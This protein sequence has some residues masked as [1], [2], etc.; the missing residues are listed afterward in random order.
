M[1]LRCCC[2][3]KQF[4]N[5]VYLP[6]G[7][8]IDN[9]CVHRQ[10]PCGKCPI[11][12][13]CF[14]GKA[15]KAFPENL[16]LQRLAAIARCRKFTALL[17]SNPSC[18]FDD[19]GIDA[20]ASVFCAVCKFRFC[21]RCKALHDKIPETRKHEMY[22][23]ENEEKEKAIIEKGN[24]CKFHNGKKIKSWCFECKLL[25]CVDCC[26]CNHDLVDIS[27][28]AKDAK[29]KVMQIYKNLGQTIT[30]IRKQQEII[31][32][33]ENDLKFENDDHPSAALRF[34]VIK[35]SVDDVYLQCF[36]LHDEIKKMLAFGGDTELLNALKFLVIQH[37]N[38]HKTSRSTEPRPESSVSSDRSSSSNHDSSA[39]DERQSLASNQLID[40]SVTLDYQNEMF[41][42]GSQK[43]KKRDAAVIP[44]N[45]ENIYMNEVS[46]F[47]G[48]KNDIRH[49][50]RSK[51][52]FT[53]YY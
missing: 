2:C 32:G 44:E 46:L 48:I 53:L 42:G 4:I 30:T 45:N 11:C 18:N 1:D 17:S 34:N 7:H 13:E 10:K 52:T 20:A 15:E 25:A 16:F 37:E 27:K 9:R 22:F 6:C 38:I 35:G 51:A 40:T 28:A 12:K 14:N 19:H 49:D 5:P 33:N 21:E 47:A 3:H 50:F 29:D 41:D 23:S 24:L 43:I 39:L 8:T 36:Y 26:P 31:K